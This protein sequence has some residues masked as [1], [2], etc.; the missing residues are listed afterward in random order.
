MGL[1]FIA[2]AWVVIILVAMLVWLDYDINN[3]DR[4]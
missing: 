4:V 2:I 1:S 3:Q